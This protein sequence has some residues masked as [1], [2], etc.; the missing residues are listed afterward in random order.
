MGRASILSQ[1]FSKQDTIRWDK[2][3]IIYLPCFLFHA[4]G[5]PFFAGLAFLGNPLALPR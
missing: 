2:G 3:N 5:R 4:F 1:I